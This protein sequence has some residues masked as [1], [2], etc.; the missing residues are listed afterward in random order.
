MLIVNKNNNKERRNYYRILNVQPDAPLDIIKNN[1]RTL[2][3]KLR[4]HPDL[5]GENWNASIINEAYNIL[6]DPE[7]RAAYD[8]SLLKRY[9]LNSL[10]RGH[11]VKS[12]LKTPLQTGIPKKDRHGNQRNYYRL[13]NIQP[14]APANIIRTIYFSLTKNSNIPRDLLN[15]AYAVLSHSDK[16]TVY[17]RLLTQYCH[18][19]AV[20]KLF[21]SPGNRT[22]K[23]RTAV[24][25]MAS[26]KPSR[27]H[28][29]KRRLYAQYNQT[30]DNYYRPVITQYCCFCKT[31]HDQSPCRDTAPLCNECNSP[32][33]PPSSTF[34]EQQRRNIVRLS[35]RNNNIHFYTYWPGK[36]FT[37]KIT[38]MSPTG[39]QLQT[40]VKLK[41][42][43]TIKLDAENFKAVGIVSYN[44]AEYEHGQDSLENYTM[45]I[46][47]I[48]VNFN[49]LKG[50]F[51]SASA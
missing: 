31:P 6:R 29:G 19:D 50:H 5:G 3:Q 14:D 28:I 11:L 32:L 46:K 4:L 21:N 30:N 36:S 45:G 27:L 48:T 24:M 10:S 44:R 34:L 13:L 42:D 2:L 16:R 17:D 20:N 12:G 9:E 8:Q 43:Q 33:F 51:F 7:K 18:A 39:L 38:D 49:K 22:T 15:E 25:N 47:F 37:G 41:K 26:S 23:S 40:S 35:Q 1:Y